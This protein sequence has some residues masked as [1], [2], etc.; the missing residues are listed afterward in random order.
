[1]PDRKLPYIGRVTAKMWITGKIPRHLRPGSRDFKIRVIAVAKGEDKEY[2][3]K[4][5]GNF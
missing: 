4:Y 5:F 3:K 2:W 1:M